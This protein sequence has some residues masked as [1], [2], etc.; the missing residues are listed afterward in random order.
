[1][2]LVTIAFKEPM[3]SCIAYASDTQ[4][5]SKHNYDFLSMESE[6]CTVGILGNKSLQYSQ[7]HWIL[8]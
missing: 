8:W 4:Q 6:A 1:M 2:I 7:V 5:I 3:L